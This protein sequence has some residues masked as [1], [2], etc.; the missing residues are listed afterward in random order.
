MAEGAARMPTPKDEVEKLLKAG[1]CADC[2][3][4]RLHLEGPSAAEV[5]IVARLAPW[6]LRGTCVMCKLLA[7]EP[8]GLGLESLPGRVR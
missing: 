5:N 1:Y 7:A 8:L 6:A 4:K 2:I 3:K